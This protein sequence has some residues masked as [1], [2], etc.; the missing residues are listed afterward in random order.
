[1]S[2]GLEYIVNVFNGNYSELAKKLN[3]TPQTVSDWIRGKRKISQSKLNDLE[4][5]FKLDK[6]LFQKE[7]TEV[8]KIEIEIE[9]LNRISRRDTL[10]VPETVYDNGNPYEIM[11]S[12]N[13]HEDELRMKHEE[14]AIQKLLLRLKSVLYNESLTGEFALDRHFDILND[15]CSLLEEDEYIEVTSQ[16]IEPGVSTVKVSALIS[17][18]YVLEN[19]NKLAFGKTTEDNFVLELEA[20]LHKYNYLSE[21]HV[22]GIKEDLFFKDAE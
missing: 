5:L 10:S 12:Y 1:M 18:I 6:E 13:P 14:L 2:I 8:E 21:D 19:R 17:L 11:S 22:L 3:I 15:V 20:L 16:G 9:Y 4:Q 7:L